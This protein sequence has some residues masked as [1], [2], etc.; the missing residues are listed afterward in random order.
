[1]TAGL[2]LRFSGGESLLKVQGTYTVQAPQQVVWQAL[3]DPA[4]LAKTLPGCEELQETTENEFQAKLTIKVGPVEGRFEGKVQLSDL[5]PPNGYRMTINGQGAPGFVNG[6]GTLRLEEED[7]AT[8]LHY[9]ID[10]QV[11]G[12]I[13][14]VGQRL[15]DSSAK[16]ITRQALEGLD[17]Q[18]KLTGQ[19]PGGGSVGATG[20]ASPSSQPKLAARF[21]GGLLAELIPR[22]RR[23]LIAGGAL[24][25][26]V[27][28]VLV[29][30]QTC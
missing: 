13:A 27:A 18:I 5:D 26:A 23:P 4:V 11:G 30:L 19:G 24:I 10:A 12:R 16:V 2:W 6:K 9:E 1:M 3:L 7:G 28:V 15:L 21:A 25:L 29:L 22:E 8:K 17:E 20:E 14:G